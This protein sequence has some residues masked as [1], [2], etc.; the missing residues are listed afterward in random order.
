MY[1]L[2]FINFTELFLMNK[3]NLNRKFYLNAKPTV[4]SNQYISTDDLESQGNKGLNNK[5]LSFLHINIR[6]FSKNK[7]LLEEL[8]YP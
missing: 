8:M 6:I 7:S 5:S 2:F 1:Y 3:N 4:F